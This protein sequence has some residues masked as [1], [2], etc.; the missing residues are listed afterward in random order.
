MKDR[1]AWHAAVHG[2]AKTQTQ[3][4]QWRTT[5]FDSLWHPSQENGVWS[6]SPTK[7]RRLSKHLRL[8]HRTPAVLGLRNKDHVSGQRQHALSSRGKAVSQFRCSVV[9]DFVIPWTAECQASLSITNSQSLLKLM[10]IESVISSNHLILCC[11]PSP[12]ALNLFQHQG[13][14]KWVSSSHN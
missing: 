2:V 13:L 4:S 14:F 12:L 8:P 7:L 11:P 9:S 6:R 5:S 10:S 3:L 1:E